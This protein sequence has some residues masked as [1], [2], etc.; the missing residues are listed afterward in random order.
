MDGMGMDGNNH[1]A[2]TKSA[3]LFLFAR[4]D[5][6]KCCTLSSSFFCWWAFLLLTTLLPCY[7]ANY[8]A[9]YTLMSFST[10]NE[11]LRNSNKPP[12]Q[13]VIII[14]WSIAMELPNAKTITWIIHQSA[15]SAIYSIM[16]SNSICSNCRCKCAFVSFD[17]K[18]WQEG[19]LKMVSNKPSKADGDILANILGLCECLNY[20]LNAKKT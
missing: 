10:C 9:N 5:S 13:F 14:W 8:T 2:N 17:T 18:I 3:S 19:G 1:H 12:M 20:M 6:Q 16:N 4:K 7:T 11:M 15:P